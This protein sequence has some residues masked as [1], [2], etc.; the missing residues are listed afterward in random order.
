M[1]RRRALIVAGAIAIAIAAGI[2]S[3][4]AVGPTRPRPSPDTPALARLDAA[5]IDARAV[6]GAA[7]TPEDQ[8]AAAR[9][10]AAIYRRAAAALPGRRATLGEAAAAYDALGAASTPT[11]YANAA[12]R[13]LEAETTLAGALPAPPAPSD[14]LIP[15]V[16]PLVLLVA[17]AAGAAVSRPSRA[18]K[19]EP[20][21]SYIRRT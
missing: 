3:G 5:R 9:H 17:A 4:D 21:I 6:L 13:A 18:P 16:L 11:A 20:S 15:P 12:D 14:P 1:T 10:L 2:W 7:G 19:P 8:R